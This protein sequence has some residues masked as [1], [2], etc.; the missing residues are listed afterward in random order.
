M[1]ARSVIK[2]SILYCAIPFCCVYHELKSESNSN[3]L[4]EGGMKMYM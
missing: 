3:V 1:E 4:T 2:T